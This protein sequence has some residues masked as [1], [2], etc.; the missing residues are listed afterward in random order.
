MTDLS[1]ANLRHLLDH[2]TP[3][4]WEYNP[5]QDGDERCIVDTDTLGSMR[6]LIAPNDEGSV[7][8]DTE[9]TLAAAAS[10]LAHEVLRMRRKLHSMQRAWLPIT[11]DPDCTPTEQDFA[12][13]VIDHIGHILG[14]HDG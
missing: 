3:G 2:S 7:C 11:T 13:H 9:L 8:S 5:G 6:I 4:S 12:A 10:D 14:D 1:T